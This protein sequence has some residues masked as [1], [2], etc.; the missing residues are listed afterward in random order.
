MTSGAA[1]CLV[2]TTQKT[3]HR[4]AEE[5]TCVPCHGQH[6]VP[7]RGKTKD[8]FPVQNSI[9]LQPRES[10]FHWLDYFPSSL[11]PA[12]GFGKYLQPGNGKNFLLFQEW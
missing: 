12:Q 6:K 9:T 3:F 11:E 8:N 1:L 7:K 5:Q 4:G 2:V 10:P